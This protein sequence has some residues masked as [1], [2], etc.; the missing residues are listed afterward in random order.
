MFAAQG[1]TILVLQSFSTILKKRS[2][3]QVHFA[4]SSVKRN[5][6][7]EVSSRELRYLLQETSTHQPLYNYDIFPI[8]SSLKYILLV[9][10]HSTS[11]KIEITLFSI[12]KY[13][14]SHCRYF[15]RSQ[16]LLQ[17]QYQQRQQLA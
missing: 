7:D 16:T 6:F 14:K 2:F 13:I 9:S 15:S 10:I 12:L 17:F 8:F 4:F 5:H 1:V 11:N 3:S